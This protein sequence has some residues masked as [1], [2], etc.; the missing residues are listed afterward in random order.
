MS[1]ASGSVRS[2]KV[3]SP[4]E[5]IGKTRRHLE[6]IA[7]IRGGLNLALPLA[8][9]VALWIGFPYLRRFGW[10]RWGYALTDSRAANLRAILLAAVI[11]QFAVM[12]VLAIN[13]YFKAND[14]LAT[15]A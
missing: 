3:K 1:E 11:V 9:T 14:Y 12:A 8:I 10:D 5:L 7:A 6:R 15:A 13:G 4:I 2:A